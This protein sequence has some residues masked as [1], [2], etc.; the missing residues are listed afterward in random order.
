MGSMV[1][2]GALSAALSADLVL[3]G[4]GGGE[5]D[6]PAT[7]TAHPPPPP[8]SATGL[9][10]NLLSQLDAERRAMAKGLEGLISELG[11]CLSDKRGEETAYTPTKVAAQPSFMSSHKAGEGGGGGKLAG[12]V[13]NL[14]VSFE[15]RGVHTFSPS[16][17]LSLSPLSTSL[18]SVTH[19]LP[20]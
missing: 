6:R 16:S 2:D 7:A 8:P 13:Q 4:R 14:E 3:Q 15:Q 17:P 9:A 19:S 12:P 10:P 5:R 1:V 18:S 20:Q 11:A